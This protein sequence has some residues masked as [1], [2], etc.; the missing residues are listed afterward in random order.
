MNSESIRIWFS[1]TQER[2]LFARDTGHARLEVHASS[3]PAIQMDWK[4]W[5]STSSH[6][7]IF[8]KNKNKNKKVTSSGFERYFF[9]SPQAENGRLKETVT[10]ME[11]F[12]H[13]YGL[14]WVGQE[15]FDIGNDVNSHPPSLPHVPAMS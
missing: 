4:W 12:L 15:G 11:R 3:L 10:E 8:Q 13:D 7:R 5:A 1:A 2:V 6:E 14:I 9:S